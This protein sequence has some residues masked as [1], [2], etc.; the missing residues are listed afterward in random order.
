MLTQN[1]P[2]YTYNTNTQTHTHQVLKAKK[3]AGKVPSEEHVDI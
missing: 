1:T 3:S 2:T